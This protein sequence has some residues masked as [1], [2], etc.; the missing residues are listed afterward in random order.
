MIDV[1][2]ISGSYSEII[3]EQI[4]KKEMHYL[5]IVNKVDTVSKAIN[6]ELLKQKIFENLQKQKIKLEKLTQ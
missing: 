6:L 2:D 5:V 3:V 1:N 4:N